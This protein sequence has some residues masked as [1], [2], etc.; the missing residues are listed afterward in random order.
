MPRDIYFP[1][2]DASLPV[3]TEAEL[4]EFANKVRLAG[5]ANVLEALLPST[6]SESKKCLIANALNFSCQVRPAGASGYSC[7]PKV[8]ATLPPSKWEM[9]LPENMSLAR[10]QK[11]ANAVDCELVSSQSEYS[12]FKALNLPAYIGFSAA[13]FDLGLAFTEYI[14][15]AARAI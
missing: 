13:A 3:A 2:Y 12:N 1:S 8:L 15:R 4:L 11:I 7:G 14:D 10:A 6:P 9:V 5:G